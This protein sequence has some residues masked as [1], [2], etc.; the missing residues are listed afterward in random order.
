[1]VNGQLSTLLY[2]ML[3]RLFSDRLINW[4]RII[5]LLCFGYRVILAAVKQGLRLHLTIAQLVQFVVQF[6][7]RE[8][9]ARWVAAQG[10]WV[11]FPF[12]SA[13]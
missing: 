7:I 2:M 4:G 9:I 1:M 13:S 8:H 3:V 12:Y 5:V 6:V 10:G 11:S